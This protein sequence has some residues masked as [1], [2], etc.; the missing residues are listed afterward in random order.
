MEK[1]KTRTARLGGFAVLLLLFSR[2]IVA[3]DVPVT[4]DQFLLLQQHNEQTPN[5]I[6][7]RGFT[8]GIL[9]HPKY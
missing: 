7:R 3:A 1:R 4:Q 9:A 5:P 2:G 6:I 8:L